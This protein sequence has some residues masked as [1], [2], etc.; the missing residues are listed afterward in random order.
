VRR[1][2]RLACDRVDACRVLVIRGCTD[3]DQHQ[4][5]Q[6][7]RRAGAWPPLDR[8]LAHRGRAAANDGRSSAGALSVAGISASTASI[9]LDE[10]RVSCEAACNVR[11]GSRWKSSSSTPAPGAARA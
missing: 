4:Q 1:R 2:L 11:P 9:E 10:A 5:H 3:D 7:A 6:R 8:D